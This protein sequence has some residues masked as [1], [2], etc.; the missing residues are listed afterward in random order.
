M[1]ATRLATRLSAA[2]PPSP[3]C[4][5]RQVLLPPHLVAVAAGRVPP[6]AA[7]GPSVVPAT[8]PIVPLLT[9]DPRALSAFLRTRGYLVR[10]ITYPTV[11]RGEERVR[12]CLHA[13]NSVDEVDG[14]A[15][16]V[17]EWVGELG[18][19]QVG[20]LEARGGPGAGPGSGPG[21]GV[22]AG[23]GPSPKE[24]ARAATRAEGG[25]FVRARL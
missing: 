23:P 7:G 9:R 15:R 8:S 6:A 20:L 22:D 25:E 21:A 10:P 12:V 4:P 13:G 2:L 1:L 18:T 11:P 5:A 16:A 17:S 24:S 19:R 14:L 3:P